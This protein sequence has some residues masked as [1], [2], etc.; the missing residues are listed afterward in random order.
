M[1]TTTYPRGPLDGDE[2]VKKSS[3]ISDLLGYRRINFDASVGELSRSANQRAH[4]EFSQAGVKKV[5]SR[6]KR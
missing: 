3:G 1:V 4:R 5:E 2:V 6:W